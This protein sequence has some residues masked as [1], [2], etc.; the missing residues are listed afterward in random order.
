MHAER[1]LR[2]RA[3]VTETGLAALGERLYSL[4]FELILE[5]QYVSYTL[6]QVVSH[7][8]MAIA[9]KYKS[10]YPNTF[11][12]AI[13]NAADFGVPSERRRLIVSSPA[14][15]KHIH[16]NY[17]VIRRSIRDAFAALSKLLH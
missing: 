9:Q 15:I 4:G 11:D 14:A 1:D 5:K 12:F 10:T 7:K 6:E 13:L 2:D 16:E 17:P 3:D 8:T